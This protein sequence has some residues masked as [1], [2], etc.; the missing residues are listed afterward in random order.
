VEGGGGAGEESGGGGVEQGQLLGL[1]RRKDG[2]LVVAAG[3]PGKLYVL[4]DR[5]AAKGSVVSEVL[6]AKLTSRWGALRWRAELPAGTSLS[7]A[8][9][10]GARAQPARP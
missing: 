8:V 4:G 2:S 9:R 10:S 3:D 6:D 7:A 1:C 5:Y